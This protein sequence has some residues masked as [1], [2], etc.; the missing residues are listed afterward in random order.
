[1]MEVYT[2]AAAKVFQTDSLIDV[3]KSLMAYLV[4]NNSVSSWHSLAMILLLL[5]CCCVLQMATTIPHNCN[6][7]LPS[8]ITITLNLTQTQ[9]SHPNPN[10]APRPSYVPIIPSSQSDSVVVWSVIT[11]H[12]YLI[13]FHQR[14]SILKHDAVHRWEQPRSFQERHVEHWRFIEHRRIVLYIQTPG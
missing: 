14:I 1:M 2:M 8:I 11:S 6:S 12:Q 3:I 9:L 4:A 10:T 7:L 13:I 5:E